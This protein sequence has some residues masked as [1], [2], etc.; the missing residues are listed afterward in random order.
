MKLNILNILDSSWFSFV[1]GA[2]FILAALVRLFSQR[3]KTYAKLVGIAAF[4]ALG[5]ALLFNGFHNLHRHEGVRKTGSALSA[6]S[7]PS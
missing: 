6:T 3:P 1:L 7:R 4:G 5:L 2:G